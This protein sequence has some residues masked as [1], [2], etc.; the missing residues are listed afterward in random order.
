LL[1]LKEGDAPT[2]F[3][4]AHANARRRKKFISILQHEG[5]TLVTEESKAHAFLD[6]FDGILGTPASRTSS[7]DL[8]RLGLPTIN[9]SQLSDRFTQE[10]VWTVIKSLPLDKASG[11]DG[12]SACFLQVAWHIIRPDVMA[13]FDAIWHLD[14]RNLHDVNGALLVLLPKLAEAT[15][16]KDFRPISLIHVIGKLVSKVLANRLAPRLPKLVQVNQSAFI[17]GRTIHD[18]FLMVQ[19][20]AKL[21][22][23]RQKPSFLFKIDI[24]RAFD[25]VAWSFLLEILAHLG[26][27]AR[28]RDWISALLSSASTKILLNATPGDRIC[29]ARG[30]C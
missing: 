28:W 9:L 24:T 19:R 11:S 7:I 18:N 5:Q 10:E 17:K 29:H 22:Y 13:A 1:W 16:V 4:H 15:S 23:A 6:F 8:H 27:P 30:L 12:F 26:F 2:K 21:L 14:M 3:F 25:S 20:S